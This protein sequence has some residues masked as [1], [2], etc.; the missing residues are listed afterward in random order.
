VGF[1][2]VE[3]ERKIRHGVEKTSFIKILRGDHVSGTL[4]G[5]NEEEKEVTPKGGSYLSKKLEDQ[6]LH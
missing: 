6:F 2:L 5:S 3:G 1:L 4:A